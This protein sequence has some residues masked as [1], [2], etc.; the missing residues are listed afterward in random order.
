MGKVVCACRV[1]A[2]RSQRL[3]VYLRGAKKGEG[4]S[5]EKK[6]SHAVGGNTR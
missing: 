3:S 1:A 6:I 4:R 2:S 5:K